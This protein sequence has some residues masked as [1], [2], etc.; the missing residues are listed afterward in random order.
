M[1]KFNPLTTNIISIILF[2]IE[3]VGINIGEIA[4]WIGYAA[5]GLFIT[6]GSSQI[7]IKAWERFIKK[8]DDR[9]ETALENSGKQIEA[10]S[11]FKQ[12]IV[13]RLAK[14]EEKNE[15]QNERL[16]KELVKTAELTGK[17][18]LITEK[19][20]Y[21]IERKRELETK[22]NESNRDKIRFKKQIEELTKK[23]TE[24]TE[25]L[26]EALE[27]IKH[28]EELGKRNTRKIEENHNE[29]N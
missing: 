11:V 22:L 9:I 19:N 27:R 17:L 2:Q 10:D 16:L 7:V 3:T 1:N 12:S 29:E 18:S 4:K 20:S 21:L 6:V 25:K 13:D 26:N 24:T 28:L 14:V 23:L 5:S 8:K 15:R